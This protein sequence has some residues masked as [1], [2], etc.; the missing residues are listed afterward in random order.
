[1]VSLIDILRRMC[2]AVSQKIYSHEEK[3]WYAYRGYL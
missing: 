2:F 1:M 3:S